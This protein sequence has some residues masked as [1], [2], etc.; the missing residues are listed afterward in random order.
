MAAKVYKLSELHE[1]FAQMLLDDIRVCQDEGIPMSSSDK[2]VI[3]AFLKNNGI[4]ADPDAED[5]KAL[6]AEFKR[7]A[8]AQRK[9]RASLLLKNTGGDSEYADLLN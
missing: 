4:T 8:E 2:A 1:K 7:D 6:D 9:I 3:A 5:M